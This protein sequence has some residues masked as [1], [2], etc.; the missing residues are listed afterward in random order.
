MH[1]G[2][3]AYYKLVAVT[4][5]SVRFT[6]FTRMLLPC[7]MIINASIRFHFWLHPIVLTTGVFIM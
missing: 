5:L 1:K 6:V 3:H 2:Y 4:G 7:I